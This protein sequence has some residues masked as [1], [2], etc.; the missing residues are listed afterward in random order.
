MIF[1]RAIVLLGLLGGAVNAENLRTGEPAPLSEVG[2]EHH[3]D[4]EV[5]LENGEREL[6]PLLPGTKCPTGHVC[7][8]RTVVNTGASPL[9]SSLQSG[10]KTPLK[11]AMDWQELNND[12]I[13]VVKVRE[14]RE[15][16]D[17]RWWIVLGFA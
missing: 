12:M 3:L 16:G 15:G 7:R 6:F 14:E 5:I 2:V 4:L 11:A 9:V 10:L 17:L 1:S 13:T 8:S